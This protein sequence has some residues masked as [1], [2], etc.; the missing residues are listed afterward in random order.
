MADSKIKN[1]KFGLSEALQN[2]WVDILLFLGFLLDMNYHF[3]GGT[4]H[5][6]LGIALAVSVIVH[7]LLHWKWIAA[8]VKR[9]L[10]KMVL[11]QR[12]KT[13]VNIL[14]FIDVVMVMMT[15]ILISK[16]VVRTLGLNFAN[17][18]HFWKTLHAL[19]ADWMIYLLGVHLALSWKWIVNM[20]KKVFHIKGKKQVAAQETSATGELA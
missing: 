9:I 6:W 7:L 17:N 13:I 18:N 4:I 10:G 5:E 16:D 2:F 19:S 1:K 15:G 11:A 12:L 14:I 8:T 3:T 20:F